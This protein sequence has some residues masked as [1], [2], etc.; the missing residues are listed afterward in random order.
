MA[1]CSSSQQTREAVGVWYGQMYHG[2]RGKART[3]REG[4]K[5]QAPGKKRGQ[6]CSR[7]RAGTLP[8]RA[9]RHGD[10]ADTM[11]PIRRRLTI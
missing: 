4:K 8:I 1:W 9:T 11:G 10:R 3:N 7:G 2:R 5:G 6:P